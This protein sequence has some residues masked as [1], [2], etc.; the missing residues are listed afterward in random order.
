LDV[1]AGLAQLLNSDNLSVSTFQTLTTVS[2][3]NQCS[4]NDGSGGQSLAFALQ[5]LSAVG[6]KN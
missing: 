6:N 5:P 1:T 4:A 3:E 2:Q